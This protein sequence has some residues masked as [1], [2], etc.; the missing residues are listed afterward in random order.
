MR[1]A[2]VATR[3]S[4]SFAFQEEQLRE[5]GGASDCAIGSLDRLW[6]VRE[7]VGVW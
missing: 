4:R 6:I 3:S 2:C 5:F 7:Q 1:R